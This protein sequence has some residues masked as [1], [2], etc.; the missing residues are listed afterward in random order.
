[1]RKANIGYT[2]TNRHWQGKTGQNRVKQGKTEQSRTKQ[3]KTV[4][5]GGTHRAPEKQT[6]AELPTT[7]VRA[8]YV[9]MCVCVWGGGVI[10]R[11]VLRP[12]FKSKWVGE[13]Y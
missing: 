13:T 7:K 1:M 6:N 4:S 2:L 12:T 11:Q 8:F 5:M 9:C 3:G 10:T